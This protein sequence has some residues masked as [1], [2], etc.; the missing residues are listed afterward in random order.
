MAIAH[1][2]YERRGAEGVEYG[3][4]VS[5]SP[6]GEGSREGHQKIF[7]ILHFKRCIC[8]QFG[9]GIFTLKGV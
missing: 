6:V 7:L 8:M 1:G 3:E 9:V 5:P 4:G 2:R